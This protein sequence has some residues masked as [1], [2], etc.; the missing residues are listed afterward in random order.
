MN[1]SEGLVMKRKTFANDPEIRSP[2]CPAAGQLARHF[3]C[4][5]LTRKCSAAMCSG[6]L[7]NIVTSHCV[8][9]AEDTEADT[10]QAAEIVLCCKSTDFAMQNTIVLCTIVHSIMQHWSIQNVLLVVDI[11]RWV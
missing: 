1:A 9:V 10:L 3:Q 11:E 7:L 2:A 5:C 6:L 4:V 8:E